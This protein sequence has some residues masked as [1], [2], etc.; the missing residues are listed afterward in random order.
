MSFGG[1]RQSAPGVGGIG[2]NKGYGRGM[3]LEGNPNSVVLWDWEVGLHPRVSDFE[4]GLGLHSDRPDRVL[5][6]NSQLMVLGIQLPAVRSDGSQSNVVAGTL[7]GKMPSAANLWRSPITSGAGS[8][9]VRGGFCCCGAIVTLWSDGGSS[10]SAQDGGAVDARQRSGTSAQDD[11]VVDARQVSGI[12]NA[13]KE[14]GDFVQG[15]YNG[16]RTFAGVLSGMPDLSSLPEP[17]VEGG[18]TRVVIPQAACA[19]K[20]DDFVLSGEDVG[21]GQNQVETGNCV[22]SVVFVYDTAEVRWSRTV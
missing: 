5:T 18:I 12:A 9:L 13:Q 17:V 20:K 16:R 15:Q 22:P 4:V 11:G 10:V 1:F 7:Y 8:S 14:T 19:C 21:D 3:G 2:G 6:S